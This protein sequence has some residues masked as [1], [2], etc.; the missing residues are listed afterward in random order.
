MNTIKLII[1]REYLSRV[2]KK[3]FL[4]MT[5]LGPIL[6]SALFVV[7]IL[8]NE[9]EEDNKRILIVDNTGLFLDAIKS[10]QGMQF[11][12]IPPTSLQKV[13]LNII[14]RTL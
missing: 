10:K 9:V 2:R 14:L 13:P 7:P 1:A 11:S 5:L 3:S 8:L 12:F 6:I 4:L